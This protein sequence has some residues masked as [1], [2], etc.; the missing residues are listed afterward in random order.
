MDERIEA[1]R[2]GLPFHFFVKE[3]MLAKAV[4]EFIEKELILKGGTA[5]NYAYI[6]K[7]FSED[8]DF[9]SFSDFSYQSSFFSVEG[10]WKF[11]NVLRWHA[12]YDFGDISDFIRIEVRMLA[13]EKKKIT[14]RYVEKRALEFF[15]GSIVAG[16]KHYSLEFLT[17]Q[18]IKV[19]GERVEGK[20]FFDLANC[21]K[22]AKP[23]GKV[24]RDV[25][26]FEGTENIVEKALENIKK[27]N[28]KELARSAMYIPRDFRPKSWRL[29]LIELKEMLGEL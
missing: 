15:H 14:R 26:K 24:I 16:V 10:P 13:K 1:M 8:L 20:D 7:R 6:H 23:R 22:I 27:A 9:D 25:E 5:L 28:A 12:K 19:A 2:V 18:K 4:A 11:R 17:A 3:K 29:L 21:L